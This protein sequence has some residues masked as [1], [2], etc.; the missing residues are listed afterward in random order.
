MMDL[1][2][3]FHVAGPMGISETIENETVIIDIDH[4]AY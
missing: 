2:E 1:E 3:T 4:G